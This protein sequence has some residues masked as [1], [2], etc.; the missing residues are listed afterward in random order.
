MYGSANC[1]MSALLK[2]YKNGGNVECDLMD[3]GEPG[4]FDEFFD[5]LHVIKN[6]KLIS[7]P[8]TY[9]VYQ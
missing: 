1:T 2:T 4:E 6:E 8:I 9:D 3:I 7:E 5:N